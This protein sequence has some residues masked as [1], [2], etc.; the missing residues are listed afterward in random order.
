MPIVLKSSNL[1]FLE[2]SGPVQTCN[3]IALRFITM[4]TDILVSMVTTVTDVPV[5]NF[6]AMVTKGTN[7]HWLLCLRERAE[8]VSVYRHFLCCFILTLDLSHISLN[9][10]VLLV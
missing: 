1:K 10:V 7:F 3:E 5:V 9:C 4:V 2:T 6:S 8:S